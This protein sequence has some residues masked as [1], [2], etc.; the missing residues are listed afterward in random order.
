MYFLGGNGHTMLHKKK[1]AS[2]NCRY[3]TILYQWAMSETHFCK[4]NCGFTDVR[5]NTDFIPFITTISNSNRKHKNLS[6][7]L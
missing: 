1:Q 6:H 2:H 4:W 5:L 3:A 7:S